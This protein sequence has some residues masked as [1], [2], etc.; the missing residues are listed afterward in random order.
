VRA[1][2][3]GRRA[4]ARILEARRRAMRAHLG[5]MSPGRRT[6]FVE[7]LEEYVAIVDAVGADDLLPGSERNL[8]EVS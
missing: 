3:R 2:A 8:K 6:M 1:T 4:A 5:R 7:L